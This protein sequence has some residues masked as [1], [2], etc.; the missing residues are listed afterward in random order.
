MNVHISQTEFYK[1]L[2]F[3]LAASTGEQRKAWA[4]TIVENDIDIKGVSGLLKCEQK[5]ATRF[6]WLLSDVGILK[7]NKLFIEL[8]FLLDLFEGLNPVYKT[9]FA[10]WWHYVGVPSENESRAIDLLFHWLL[11]SDTNVTIKSRSLWVLVKL[12]KKYPELKNELQLCLKD[13]VDKHTN[14]F[15]K[16]ATKILVQIEQ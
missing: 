14:E 8:P 10:G 11:S 7:P 6:L 1:E 13:Q 9:S 2:E 5:I 15:K 16:R 4:A 3:S 12:T